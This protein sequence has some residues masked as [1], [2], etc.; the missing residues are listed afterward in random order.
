MERKDDH[1]K[2]KKQI[3]SGPSGRHARLKRLDA[4]KRDER[5][6]ARFSE[7]LEQREPL[8]ALAQKRLDMTDKAEP[9]TDRIYKSGWDKG[10]EWTC[11]LCGRMLGKNLHGESPFQLARKHAETCARIPKREIGNK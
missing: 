10:G 4:R 3:V 1:G 7:W 2:A 11:P 6:L 9:M 8:L 5:R